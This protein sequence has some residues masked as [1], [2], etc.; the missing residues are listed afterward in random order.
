[1]SAIETETYVLKAGKEKT[2]TKKVGEEVEED[3]EY[4]SVDLLIIC[5][6]YDPEQLK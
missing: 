4:K 3:D 2:K 5:L 1:M 6:P